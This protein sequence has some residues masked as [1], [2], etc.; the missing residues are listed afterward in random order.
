MGRG[1]HLKRKCSFLAGFIFLYKTDLPSHTVCVVHRLHA[2]A[3]DALDVDLLLATGQGLQTL[4]VVGQVRHRVV[5]WA[6]FI[7]QQNDS[8]GREGRDIKYLGPPQ[9][10]VLFIVLYK[11]PCVAM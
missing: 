6:S 7:S 9:S 8:K 4:A 10:S 3:V 5:G 2:A 11:A 1:I